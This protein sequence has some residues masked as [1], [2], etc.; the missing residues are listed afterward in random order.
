MQN[1]L[2]L[3]AFA[4]I[5]AGI[6][7]AFEIDVIQ[8][9]NE[10]S[11]PFE[12]RERKIKEKVLIS[13]GQKK[14]NSFTILINDTR[15]ILQVTGKE[16]TFPKL[17]VLSILA[18]LIGMILGFTMTNY[19]IVPVL[20]VG[21]CTI[22]FIYIK[23]IGSKLK[24]QIS[25]ELET[26][27]SI[28]TSSYIRSELFIQA[29]EE[30]ISYIN[31]PVKEVFE[32]FVL[33]SNHISSD[34]IK[35]LRR[36]KSRIDNAVFKEWTDAVISCQKDANL[37][38]TL[39]PIVKKLSNIRLVSVRLDSLLYAP[40]KEFVF[41]VMLLFFNIPM[42]YFVNK[43][44]FDILINYTIGKIVMTICAVAVLFSTAG[45]IRLTRP[46]EYKR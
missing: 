24:R 29:V 5:L 27:L 1:I 33:E 19:F 40:I 10:L 34:T 46:I 4:I 26:A 17:C 39:P 44:W 9:L 3:L 31:T 13:T 38:Y 21:F 25:E 16:D 22:P 23:V 42:F 32:R 6:F 2:K 28:I 45:V 14:E 15:N 30:N 18:A 36:L 41:L 12:P 11:K 20:S 7:Y 43:I 8:F 37:K 35:N